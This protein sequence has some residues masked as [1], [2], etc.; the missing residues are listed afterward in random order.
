MKLVR[1][2]LVTNKSDHSFVRYST[3]FSLISLLLI[4]SASRYLLVE[5]IFGC[6]NQG[7]YKSN[8]GVPF[9][10]S[11]EGA[12]RSG[13]PPSGQVYPMSIPSPSSYMFGAQ[14]S[15]K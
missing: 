10:P 4:A 3:R 7:M 15:M 12:D 8:K 2:N 9:M 11:Y 5:G 13:W 14:P 1:Y 6:L